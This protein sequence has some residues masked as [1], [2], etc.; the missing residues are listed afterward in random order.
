MDGSKSQ[1][2]ACR[3]ENQSKPFSRKKGGE[4]YKGIA[5]ENSGAGVNF[6]R[7]EGILILTFFSEHIKLRIAVESSWRA[8]RS[9]PMRLPRR[10]R[11][12]Q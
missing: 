11:S 3:L 5:A 7:T 8:K 6:E 1:I 2:N 12:S 9:N 10:C 4:I